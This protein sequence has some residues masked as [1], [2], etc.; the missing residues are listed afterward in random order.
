MKFYVGSRYYRKG[1]VA[2][3]VT[4]LEQAGHEVTFDWTKHAP[5]KPFKDFPQEAGETADYD[6]Q[7][8]LQAG[9]Y[10]LL[11][12]ADGTGVFAELGAALAS[13]A[14]TGSPR[15]YAVAEEVP[16]TMFHYHPA[17]T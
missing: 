12:H 17:I 4:A 10:I 1:E 6:L 13:H 8:V 9:V 14:L 2:E 5:N 7:G 15:L 16:N 3:L 11:A